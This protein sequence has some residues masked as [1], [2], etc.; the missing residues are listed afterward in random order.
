MV[1]PIPISISLISNP[2]ES[3]EVRNP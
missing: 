1:I 2:R 3:H